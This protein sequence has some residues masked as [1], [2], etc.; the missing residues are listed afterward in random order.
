MLVIKLLSLSLKVTPVWRCGSWN[1]CFSRPAGAILGS[2]TKR[3]QRGI[4]KLRERERTLLVAMSFLW[5]EP[6]VSV[7]RFLQY[8]Q[9]QLLHHVST[10]RFTKLPC[11][12]RPQPLGFLNSPSSLCIVSL[13]TKRNP[14]S[15]SKDGRGLCLHKDPVSPPGGGYS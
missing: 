6:S 14:N 2:A 9:C 15:W 3:C 7:S 13:T 5:A 10:P 8:S 1:C 4:V 11:F 12:K